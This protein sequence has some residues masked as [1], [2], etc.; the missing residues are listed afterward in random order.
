MRNGA[1]SRS[2][3]RCMSCRLC[4]ALAAPSVAI[5]PSPAPMLRNT[6]PSSIGFHASGMLAARAISL[7]RRDA[8]YA[9]GHEKSNQNSREV[10]TCG[11]VVLRSRSWDFPEQSSKAKL[12]RSDMAKLVAGFKDGRPELGRSTLLLPE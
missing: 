4:A 2:A 3:Q 1:A 7:A 8:R 10:F 6:P 11:S 9:Y 12:G 5:G